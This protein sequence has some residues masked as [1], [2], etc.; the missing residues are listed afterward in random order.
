MLTFDAPWSSKWTLYHESCGISPLILV[1]ASE[2]PNSHTFF[3]FAQDDEQHLPAFVS[4]VTESVSDSGSMTINEVILQV[5]RS[6]GQD[7]IATKG[8]VPRSPEYSENEDEHDFGEDGEE[9]SEEEG[10]EA[11]ETQGDVEDEDTNEI[12]D[13]YDDFD[14]D[15]EDDHGPSLVSQGT[16]FRIRYLQRSVY[17]L[18]LCFPVHDLFLCDSSDFNESVAAG[19]RP[20]MI[21]IPTCGMVVSMSI[22]VI[23]LA[24]VIAPRALM[25]WD[26]RLLSKNQHL[27]L[28]ISGMCNTYPIL[29]NDGTL[30][31]NSTELQ[32]RVGL[33][34]H[35][36]PSK[37]YVTQ[38]YSDVQSGANGNDHQASMGTRASSEPTEQEGTEDNPSHFHFS[39]STS[40]EPL[41]QD[42]FLK[43]LQ[44][45]LEYK[46]GWAGAELLAAEC[47]KR[48]ARPEHL[49]EDMLQV[50]YR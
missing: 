12:E 23:T 32:F 10:V 39:L 21:Y 19:Y 29:Q 41:L 26:A 42:R 50:R 27:T 38:I 7:S 18:I 22:P 24:Q 25:A 14:D 20:G 45:R 35:Y 17:P 43:A 15:F 16:K 6:L 33:T 13:F 31:G 40:L 49:V 47:V 1:D 46:I 5:L 11:G 34:S 28:L 30:S 37:E 9:E 48:Q 44:L 8:K 36:K 2:Y 4:Q 3:C